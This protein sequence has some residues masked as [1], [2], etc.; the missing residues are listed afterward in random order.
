MTRFKK[1]FYVK[2]GSIYGEMSC[3]GHEL[4]YCIIL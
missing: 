2:K 1:K 3:R 4:D